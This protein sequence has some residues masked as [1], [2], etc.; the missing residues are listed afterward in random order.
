MEGTSR[1]G[2]YGSEVRGRSWPAATPNRNAQ[3]YAKGAWIFIMAV[4]QLNQSI[5]ALPA[6]S[7]E[8]TGVKDNPEDRETAWI[9]KSA[10]RRADQDAQEK[11][12]IACRYRQQ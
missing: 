4:R 1:L 6:E 9:Q 12:N 5:A 10:E 2:V 8:I 3:R 11:P 7:P